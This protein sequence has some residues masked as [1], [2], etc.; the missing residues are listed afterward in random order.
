MHNLLRALLNPD[1]KVRLNA[2]EALALPIFDDFRGTHLPLLKGEKLPIYTENSGFSTLFDDDSAFPMGSIQSLEK[3]SVMLASEDS[4][5]HQLS[6]FSVKYEGQASKL[7]PHNSA[8]CQQSEKGI[9][10]HLGSCLSSS[11][12]KPR[13]H[14]MGSDMDEIQ[15]RDDNIS[16]LASPNIN[17]RQLVKSNSIQMRSQIQVTQKLM[18]KP[19]IGSNPNV[20]GQFSSEFASSKNPQ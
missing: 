6:L 19:E 10:S 13:T 15:S 17:P 11:F 2:K 14:G 18:V 9:V 8:L 3:K 20:V 4:H 7:V 5:S 1:P 12:K 16:P